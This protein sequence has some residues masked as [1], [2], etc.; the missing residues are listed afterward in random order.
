MKNIAIITGGDSAEYSISLQS[1]QTVRNN[2]PHYIKSYMVHVKGEHWDVLIDQQYVPVNKNNFSFLQ[3]GMPIQ[4]DAVFMALHGPPAENGIIQHYFDA[5]NIPYTCCSA[6]ISALTFDKH[7]CNNQLN[8]C[9]YTCATSFLLS[10]DDAI[11]EEKI[12]TKV[13]L[14][15]F[16]KPNA[17]GSSY[18]VSKVTIQNELNK[19][20]STAFVHDKQVLIEQFIDGVEVSCGVYTDGNNTQTFPITEIV[21]ENDFFDYEA[22]YEGKSKEIT[23][24]RITDRLTKNIQQTTQAIYNQMGLEGICRIDYII[25]NDI[26]YIIE[27]NTIPGL[28]D[29]SI[30]PKQIS[31]AE[32]TLSKIFEICLLN[33]MNK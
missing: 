5:L 26:P 31:T 33:S 27:I 13:G 30:I 25:M 6:A 12:I 10:E 22:K 19:A 8:A 18:G 7:K 29:E 23:P 28:S 16:V 11:D 32:L 14:P 21:S 9:G 24:A 17:S 2:L 20:I 1:A 3:N 15:C 4:F